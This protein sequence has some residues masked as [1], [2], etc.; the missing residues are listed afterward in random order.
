MRKKQFYRFVL[1]DIKGGG[2]FFAPQGT[3]FN[4]GIENKSVIGWENIE[5]E[6]KEGG[7]LPFM[8]SD[9]VANFVNKELKDLIEENTPC[10]YPLEFFPIQVRG[11]EHG[12]KIYYL[13]H[14]KTVFDV[15]D[16]KNS[17]WV[18]ES[19]AKPWIDYEK[20]KELDFFNST[21]RINGI[22]VSDKMKKLMTKN[23]LDIGIEFLKVPYVE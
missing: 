4:W 9:V 23:K 7:Y 20:A 8:S 3:D 17:V 11:G 22:I 19:I 5:F 15:I 12:D 10:D 18:A 6:L 14:F 13:I 21:A 16:S 2:I 1:K